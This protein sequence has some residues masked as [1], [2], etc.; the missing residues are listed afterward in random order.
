MTQKQQR[1]AIATAARIAALKPKLD[2]LSG[3]DFAQRPRPQNQSERVA[4][5]WQSPETN[6]CNLDD[7]ERR[8]LLAMTGLL[9]RETAVNSSKL[10]ALSQTDTNRGEQGDRLS[11][12]ELDRVL[13]LSDVGR[14]ILRAKAK[15]ARRDAGI[16][17]GW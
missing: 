14:S 16:P 15:Q 3:E 12:A 5:S 4:F 1:M 10:A 8:R 11:R 6:N 13:A 7:T 9:G 2:A 17:G